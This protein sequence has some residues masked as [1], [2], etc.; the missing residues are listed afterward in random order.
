MTLGKST[1]STSTTNHKDEEETHDFTLLCSSSAS[2]EDLAETVH[3]LYYLPSNYKLIVLA[4]DGKG[5]REMPWADASIK[6]RIHFSSKE[7][8]QT[9]LSNEKQAAPFSCADAV[10]CDEQSKSMFRN[11]SAPQIRIDT[12]IHDVAKERNGFRV[13]FGDPEAMATALLRIAHA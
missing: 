12:H 6:N 1:P 10:V 13:P 5:R 7:N 11:T 3:A 8:C 4:A 2:A 9:E